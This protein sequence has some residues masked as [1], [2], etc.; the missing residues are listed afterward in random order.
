MLSEAGSA[1]AD[2]PQS[3][4]PYVINNGCPPPGHYQIIFFQFSS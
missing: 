4:H 1:Q 2:P 3:K